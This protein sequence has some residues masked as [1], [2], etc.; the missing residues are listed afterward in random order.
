MGIA[1]ATQKGGT[2]M[3][4]VSNQF[5]RNP[6]KDDRLDLNDGFVIIGP[7]MI[8][9]GIVFGL[10]EEPHKLCTQDILVILSARPGVYYNIRH[11]GVRSGYGHGEEVLEL[12]NGDGSLIYR[13]SITDY[14]NDPNSFIC[15]YEHRIEYGRYD[16]EIIPDPELIQALELKRHLEKKFKF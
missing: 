4:E 3:T 16:G 14:C 7:Y 11:E 12:I 1:S 9:N 5:L 8:Q 2:N 13:A 10:P 15:S 6:N